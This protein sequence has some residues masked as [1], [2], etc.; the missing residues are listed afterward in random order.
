MNL[1][2]S[3][4]LQLAKEIFG[5]GVNLYQNEMKLM[6][7]ICI[8]GEGMALSQLPDAESTWSF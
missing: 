2:Q 8:S 6:L 3:L 1:L 4:L 5:L 7:C